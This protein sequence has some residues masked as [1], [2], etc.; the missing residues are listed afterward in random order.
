MDELWEEITAPDQYAVQMMN[1]SKGVG[2]AAKSL[3]DAVEYLGKAAKILQDTPM[4]DRILS[5]ANTVE[6]IG[7]DLRAMRDRFREGVRE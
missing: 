1:A 5:L 4:E 7:Y 6:D 3:M 2:L